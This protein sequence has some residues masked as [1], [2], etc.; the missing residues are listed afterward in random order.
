MR[1]AE[2]AVGLGIGVFFA[3]CGF[4]WAAFGTEVFLTYV[5][6]GLAWCL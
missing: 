3:G 4:A 6:A 2:A 5:E 1:S